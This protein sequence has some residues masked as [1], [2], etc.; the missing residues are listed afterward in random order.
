MSQELVNPAN[1]KPIKLT[2][3]N[4]LFLEY[5]VEGLPVIEAYKKAGYAGGVTAAYDL[6]HRLKDDFTR[7]VHQ[8]VSLTD[9]LHE[10]EKLDNLPLLHTHITLNQKI[11]LIQLKLQA[12]KQVKE[13]NKPTEKFTAFVINTQ[14]NET[15]VN[16]GEVQ[17]GQI[18][19]EQ[20]GK[21]G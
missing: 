6:K 5:L 21:A 20:S 9:T 19:D 1:D 12:M 14:G 4:R 3:K 8:R 13:E 18:V 16:I 10:I 17:E 15:K 11:R 7:L 2:P